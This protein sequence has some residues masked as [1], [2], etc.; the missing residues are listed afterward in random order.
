MTKVSNN[1]LAVV[2]TYNRKELLYKC[3]EALLNQTYNK[4][5]I[6]IV[7]NN[8]T[9]NTKEY[10]DNLIDDKRVKY[11]NTL[12]NIGGAGG[13]NLGLKESIE[14][15]YDYT[16]MMDDDTICDE[17]ALEKL[18]DA[19]K[20]LKKD[21]GFLASSV[22]FNDNVPCQM[23]KQKIC[24]DWYNHLHLLDSGII[25]IY[26]ST[27]VS[28]F[29]KNEVAKKEGLP[30]KEFFIWGD[31]VEY[32]NRLSKKY[33]CF[34]VSSSKVKHKIKNNVGSNIA[35]DDIDRMKR[36][37]YAYRNEIYIA[38]KNGMYGIFRQLAKIC[39]HI[40]R[41]IVKSKKYKLRKIWI[42]ISASFKGLFFNPKVEYIK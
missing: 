18:M 16:W 11:K 30:I 7:D 9:D 26:H 35:L 39:L 14:N 27:F 23:N 41:V 34:L 24:K 1:I 12:K 38:K 19:S 29:I 4:F 15:K 2:V 32:T 40:F 13:F 8:S 28:F 36:Y 6:L 42:I 37:K 10:I 17:T 3:I 20:I 31:D 22:F 21:Y 5:D 25:K 33:N